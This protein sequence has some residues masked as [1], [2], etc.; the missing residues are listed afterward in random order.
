MHKLIINL[1]LLATKNNEICHNILI[2]INYS[3][4][5]NNFLKTKL[6]L[7]IMEFSNPCIVRPVI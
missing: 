5:S 6:F 3:R 2:E 1:L 7:E 4:V